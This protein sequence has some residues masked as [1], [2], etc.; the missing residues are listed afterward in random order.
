MSCGY[1]GKHCHLRNKEN[2]NNDAGKPGYAHTKKLA[3]SFELS[4]L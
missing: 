4:I 3:D 2:L 1:I